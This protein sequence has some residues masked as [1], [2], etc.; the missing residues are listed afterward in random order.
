M[1]VTAG[2]FLRALILSACFS[3]A[4]I[5]AGTALAQSLPEGPGSKLVENACQ[6][7]HGLDTITS[8][9]HDADGWRNTVINMINRGAEIPDDDQQ[10]VIDYLTAHY[11][12]AGSTPAAPAAPAPAQ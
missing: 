5:A 7:C 11:G 6:N 4:L 9:H 8:T 10:A 12:P 1:P 3:A 2:T